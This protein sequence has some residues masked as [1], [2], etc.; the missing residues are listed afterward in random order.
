[1]VRRQKREPKKTYSCPQLTVYGTVRDLTQ[2]TGSSGHLDGAAH[3][4]VK[5]KTHF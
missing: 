1:M 2:K 5:N 4:A 3:G